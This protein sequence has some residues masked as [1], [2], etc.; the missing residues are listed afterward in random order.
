MPVFPSPGDPH[1]SLGSAGSPSAASQERQ[2]R[3]LGPLP[4]WSLSLPHPSVLTVNSLCCL[5]LPYL[6]HAHPGPSPSSDTWGGWQGGVAGTAQVGTWGPYL[7]GAASL[8]PCPG[9]WGWGAVFRP[10]RAYVL[11]YCL[12]LGLTPAV[13]IGLVEGVDQ[14][15]LAGASVVVGDE[16]PSPAILI[17]HFVLFSMSSI[18]PYPYALVPTP[19]PVLSVPS[20]STLERSPSGP[21]PRNS[22]WCSTPAPQTSGCPLSTARVMPAVSYLP[23]RPT[24]PGSDPQGQSGSPAE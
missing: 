5:L 19:D 22:P 12:L 16:E 14:H 2:E 23:F 7:S 18:S 11:I 4:S 13:V 21:H 15:N 20:V 3:P 1:L 24:P 8:C 10:G 17:P 6:G 9:L